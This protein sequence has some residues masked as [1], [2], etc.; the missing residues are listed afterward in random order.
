MNTGLSEEKDQARGAVTNQRENPRKRSARVSSSTIGKNLSEVF[1]GA[2]ATVPRAAER[3]EIEQVTCDSRK[4]RQ[5]ALFFALHGAKA[6]GNA[7]VRDSLKRGA[8]AIASEEAA[9]AT[10]PADVPWIQVREARKALAIAAA[11][12]YGHPARAL[13]LV[14][15]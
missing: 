13:E 12:F 11:N 4:V 14:A 5:G 7:F 10:S 2:E 8:A 15:V 3:I 9:P 6:D 1:Q